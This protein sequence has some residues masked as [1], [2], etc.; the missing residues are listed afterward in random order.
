MSRDVTVQ[1]DTLFRSFTITSVEEV[2]LGANLNIDKLNRFAF[3]T[4]I[5]VHSVLGIWTSSTWLNLVT[6]VWFLAMPIFASALAASK[7]KAS[8]KTGQM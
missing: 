3:K 4:Y 2:T 1:L 6:V 5:N 8:F 7:N